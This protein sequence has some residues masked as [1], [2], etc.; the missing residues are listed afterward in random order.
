MVGLITGFIIGFLAS[1]PVGPIN[2]S[3]ISTTIHTGYKQGIFIALGAALMDFIYM[4]LAL[5]GVSLLTFNQDIIYTIQI[6][7]ILLITVI[8]IKEI[9]VKESKFIKEEK[10]AEKRPRKR[11]FFALGVAFYISNPM[12]LAFFAG[13]ATWLKAQQIITHDIPIY[14]L[15]AVGVGIG[16]LSWFAL[17]GQLVSHYKTRV[18]ISLLMKINRGSGVVL[19]VLALFLAYKI[20]LGDGFNSPDTEMLDMFNSN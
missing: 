9:L 6:A 14:L 10:E 20:L 3:L 19:L 8:G 1:V 18:S 2:M 4:L 17:L 15:T 16:S 11:K 12:I 13:I 7:G 5:F